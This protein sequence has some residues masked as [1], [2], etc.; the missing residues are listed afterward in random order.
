MMLQVLQQYSAARAAKQ[1]S[2]KI[3]DNAGKSGKS[4]IIREIR[5]IRC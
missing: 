1:E 2:R 5:K 3:P 4:G